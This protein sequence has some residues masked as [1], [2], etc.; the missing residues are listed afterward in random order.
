MVRGF[1]DIVLIC[2]V[3]VVL[4]VKGWCSHR[5]ICFLAHYGVL[6]F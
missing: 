3:F 1:G 4:L 6:F 2:I 5:S